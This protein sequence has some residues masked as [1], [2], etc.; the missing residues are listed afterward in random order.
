MHFCE[1]PNFKYRVN[2]NSYYH[3]LANKVCSA[4]IE[5]TK[6]ISLLNEDIA[7]L[8]KYCY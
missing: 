8:Y 6:Y 7:K 1:Q 2:P 3:I 4:D 5:N